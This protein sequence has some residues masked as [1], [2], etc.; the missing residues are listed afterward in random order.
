MSDDKYEYEL[1]DT[2]YLKTDKDQQQRIVTGITF[3]PGSVIYLLSC[4]SS[5]TQHYGI[6]ITTEIDIVLKTDN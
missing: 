2:V 1:G 4:G 5:E 3:R 6:E